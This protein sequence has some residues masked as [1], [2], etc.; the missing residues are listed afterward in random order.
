MFSGLPGLPRALV[1][2]S[3]ERPDGSRR[4]HDPKGLSVL[5]QHV[6]FFD[7][8]AACTCLPSRPHLIADNC[9]PTT[10][11]ARVARAWLYRL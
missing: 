1:A 3:R 4:F 9:P 8:S 6:E 5:Q 11:A 10:R 7:R 2:P